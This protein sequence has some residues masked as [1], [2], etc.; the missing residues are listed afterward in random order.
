M[1]ERVPHEVDPAALPG[2]GQHLRDGRLDTLMAVG[3]DELDAAQTAPGQLAQER[4]L[5]GLGLG[6]ADIH[7]QDL[8]PSIAVDAGGDPAKAW[9]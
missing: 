7:A 8:A 2:C 5:E 3:D 6:E 4:R 1:G 9:Q